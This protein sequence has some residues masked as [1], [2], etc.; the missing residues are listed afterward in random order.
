MGNRSSF[1]PSL[2]LLGID[3]ELASVFIRLSSQFME[4]NMTGFSGF[5]YAE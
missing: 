2:S 4:E 3:L 1:L 5:S